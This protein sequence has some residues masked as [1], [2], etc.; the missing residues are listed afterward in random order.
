MIRQYL[1]MERCADTGSYERIKYVQK[2]SAYETVLSCILLIGG[3]TIKQTP[4]GMKMNHFGKINV[5]KGLD[6]AEHKDSI[7][8]GSLICLANPIC[9]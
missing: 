3:T 1:R 5:L 4:Y 8:D 7:R 6:P 2:R 9:Q